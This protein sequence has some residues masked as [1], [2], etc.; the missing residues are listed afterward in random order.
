MTTSPRTAQKLINDS[1]TDIAFEDLRP[2]D[3]FRLFESTG[4]PVVDKEDGKATDTFKAIGEPF[5]N[6]NNVWEV[7]DEPVYDA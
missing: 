2:G 3:I 5:L 1:W 4:E 7:Q 6:A